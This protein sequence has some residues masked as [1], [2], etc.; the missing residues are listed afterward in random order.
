MLCVSSCLFCLCFQRL[1]PDLY[2]AKLQ[3]AMGVSFNNGMESVSIGTDSVM[4]MTDECGEMET[5]SCPMSTVNGV[6]NV[7]TNGLTNSSSSSVP[8]VTTVG[9]SRMTAHTCCNS[10]A[11]LCTMSF[12]QVKKSLIPVVYKQPY[13]QRIRSLR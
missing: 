11:Q 10:R 2:H 13:V 8:P 12:Q 9:A 3:Q 7:H 1:C 6:E 5:S 4:M